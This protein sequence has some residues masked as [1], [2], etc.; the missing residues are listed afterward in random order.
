LYWSPRKGVQ[1]ML[2]LESERDRNAAI[3]LARQF[4]FSCNV[5]EYN[6]PFASFPAFHVAS[7]DQTQCGNSNQGYHIGY[8]AMLLFYMHAHWSAISPQ[9]WI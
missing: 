1:F 9:L 4:A 7:R 6:T 8:C 3:M 2:V 5:C